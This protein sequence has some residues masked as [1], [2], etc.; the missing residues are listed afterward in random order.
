MVVRYKRICSLWGY[1][2]SYVSCGRG[3]LNGTGKLA[4]NKKGV[5]DELIHH[6]SNFP[7]FP[8]SVQL[9]MKM[10]VDSLS[11]RHA[12]MIMSE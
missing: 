3:A 6:P 4:K 9:K 8:N 1:I 2:P 11:V 5:A 12:I 10:S 7:F